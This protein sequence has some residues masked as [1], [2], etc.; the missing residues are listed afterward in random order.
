MISP[1]LVKRDYTTV[2][3]KV[4]A[5][6]QSLKNQK[7]NWNMIGCPRGGLTIINVKQAITSSVKTVTSR[8][9]CLYSQTCFDMILRIIGGKLRYQSTTSIGRMKTILILML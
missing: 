9:L 3:A 6:A 2:F 5:N 8:T 1:N 4:W 7:S